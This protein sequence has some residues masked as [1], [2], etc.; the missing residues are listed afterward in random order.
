MS[1]VVW[2]LILILD[3]FRGLFCLFVFICIFYMCFLIVF[4]LEVLLGI[5]EGEIDFGFGVFF[6]KKK[7]VRLL[8]KKV[9]RFF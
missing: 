5:V 8:W 4:N 6:F 3:S 2:V 7:M 9:E 1:I